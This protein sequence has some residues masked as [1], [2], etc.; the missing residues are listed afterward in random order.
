MNKTALEKAQEYEDRCLVAVQDAFKEL[1]QA[2]IHHEK[3]N[4]IWVDAVRK[5]A[6]LKVKAGSGEK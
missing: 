2:K 3:Q 4:A 6:E 5:R 1:C